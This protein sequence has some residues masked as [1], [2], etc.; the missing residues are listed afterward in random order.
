MK[1][2]LWVF[3]GL[4]ALS[5]CGKLIWLVTARLPE[6]K[7]H[8]EAFDVLMNAAFIGWAAWLLASQ[9]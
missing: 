6:R 8:E 5:A 1:L 2:F 9:S 7:P 3:I 4:S